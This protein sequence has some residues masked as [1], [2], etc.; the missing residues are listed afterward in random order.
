MAIVRFHS[1][2]LQRT[3]QGHKSLDVGWVLRRNL[4]AI[5]RLTK[6]PLL[7]LGQCVAKW[8]QIIFF[9]THLI[10]TALSLVTPTNFISSNSFLT[11]LN[12]WPQLRTNTLTFK[13]IS[14]SLNILC[15]TRNVHERPKYGITYI[16]LYMHNIKTMPNL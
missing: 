7:Y 5:Q 8:R 1:S 4:N 2:Q 11:Q 14:H 13:V 6:C 10:L 3:I 12:L 15:L 9:I 16:F